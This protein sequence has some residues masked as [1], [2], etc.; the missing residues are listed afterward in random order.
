MLVLC[1]KPPL[2]MFLETS[3]QLWWGGVEKTLTHLFDMVSKCCQNFG[4]NAVGMNADGPD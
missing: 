3:A 4:D 2:Q 1:P